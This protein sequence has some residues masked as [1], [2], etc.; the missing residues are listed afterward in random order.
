MDRS[1]LESDPHRVLEGMADRRLRRRGVGRLHLRARRVSPGHQAPAAPPFAR[2][3]ASACSATT[4]A[5]PRF[6]FSIDIRLGAGAFV[7]GE[8]TALIASIEG[9]RGMPRPRPPYPADGRP[10]GQPTLINN[11]ETFANIAPIIRNGGEWYRRDR[12]RKEQGHQGLRPGR[13]G[14]EH[15]P[16]RSAHGHHAARD[17]L[18]HRRR[19]SRRPRNSRRCRPA[20]PPA[21]ASPR[22][23]S[24]CRS[25]TNRC[26]GSAPSW[27][28]AA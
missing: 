28:P 16:G 3:S 22:S 15:R 12:H 14:R 10:L 23:T 21:A 9:K 24:T 18:R 8:E 4:S 17:R 27:A 26:Q 19:H 6:S 1:V 2:P 5:A 13:Q 20:A 7:C 11:V 25:T